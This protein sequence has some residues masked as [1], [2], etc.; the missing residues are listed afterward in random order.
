MTLHELWENTDC[1]C[2]VFVEVLNEDEEC[3]EIREYTGD[4]QYLFGSSKVFSIRAEYIP[5]VGNVIMCLL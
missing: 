5:E 4:E 1:N 2:R 3:R